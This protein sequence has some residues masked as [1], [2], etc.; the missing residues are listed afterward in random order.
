MLV[1]GRE[2]ES[3]PYKHNTRLQAME[4]KKRVGLRSTQQERPAEW[5]IH[6]REP[7]V[8]MAFRSRDLSPCANPT[9]PR[10]QATAVFPSG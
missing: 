3:D 4:T 9:E 7:R 8:G 2:R 6:L 5:Q 10:A 1:P